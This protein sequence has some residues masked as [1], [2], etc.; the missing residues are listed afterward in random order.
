MTPIGV[1]LDAVERVLEAGTPHDAR[2]SRLRRCGILIPAW[3][4]AIDAMAMGWKRG[5]EDDARCGRK[6]VRLH[7]LEGDLRP[8]LV[9]EH[10]SGL[11]RPAPLHHHRLRTLPRRRV[12]EKNGTPLRRCGG[13][14]LCIDPRVYSRRQ[15]LESGVLLARGDGERFAVTMSRV[16]VRRGQARSREDVVELV[17]ED[18]L[19]R[20]SELAGGVGA[21]ERPRRERAPAL[22]REQPALRQ[23]VR[24]LDL[25]VRRVAARC[26]ILE[27]VHQRG[28][29]LGVLRDG[30]GERVDRAEARVRLRRILVERT[31]AG[32]GLPARTSA[33]VADAITQ[34]GVRQSELPCLLRGLAYEIAEIVLPGSVVPREDGSPARGCRRVPATRRT[35]RATSSRPLPVGRSSR[36]RNRSSRGSAGAPRCGRS[37][38]G[39]SPCARR[40]RASR[41]TTVCRTGHGGRR[42]RPPARCNRAAPTSRRSR[43]SAR[44]LRTSG[45][46]RKAPVPPPRSTRTSRPPRG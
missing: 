9:E 6:D 31:Q 24:A 39:S 43:A 3:Y 22:R 34:D 1:D 40:R 5:S 35:A 18:L 44:R 20:A 4:E 17:E 38:P 13:L 45:S 7:D 46:L 14:R 23:A 36:C 26:V 2:P 21:A 37:C 29:D 19:P 30:G 15:D 8:D 10:V 42:T 28:E 25:G 41:G 33:V 12:E 16:V 11:A 32:D 27:V